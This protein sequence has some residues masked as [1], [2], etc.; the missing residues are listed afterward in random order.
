L[1]REGAKPP[2]IFSPPLEQ[3]KNR[4]IKIHLFE[5]GIKGVSIEETDCRHVPNP[6]TSLVV[7][8]NIKVRGEEK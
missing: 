2:L 7:T 3:N 6:L 5:R 1:R 4:A 8:A